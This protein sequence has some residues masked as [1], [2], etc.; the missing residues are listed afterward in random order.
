MLASRLR[1]RP[2]AAG[3]VD[4]LAVVLLFALFAANPARATGEFAD[5]GS[6]SGPPRLAQAALAGAGLALVATG[7]IL[8][9]TTDDTARYHEHYGEGYVDV[10]IDTDAHDHLMI[11]GAVSIGLALIIEIAHAAGGGGGGGGGNDGEPDAGGPA[12][13]GLAPV[14]LTSFRPPAGGAG[15]GVRTRF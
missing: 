10:V 5:D 12:A 14:G 6:A 9:G 8:K 15:L 1:S 7:A 4:H 13:E 2:F 11:A 3:L